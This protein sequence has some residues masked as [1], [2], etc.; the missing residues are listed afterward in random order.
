ML[1]KLRTARKESKTTIYDMA[2]YLHI[3]PSFYS[4]IENEKRRLFYDTAIKI[5]YYFQVKPSEL[6]E[7]DLKIER[8]SKNVL[9][10]D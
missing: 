8:G 1:T 9:P 6:F 5:A 3:S 7:I 2:D 10:Y 4:Q